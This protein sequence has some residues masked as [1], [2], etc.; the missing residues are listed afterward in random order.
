M[1]KQNLTQSRLKEL[2]HYDPLTGVFTWLVALSNRVKV[3]DVIG[4]LNGEGY[5]YGRVD[6]PLYLIHRLAFLYITGAFPPEDVDHE[7]H[8]RA[9][10]RWTNLRHATRTE[11][12]QNQRLSQRSTSGHTGVHWCKDRKKWLAHVRVNGK[13][14]HLGYFTKKSDAVQTRKAANVKYGFH[15]NH[16]K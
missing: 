7:N 4:C 12:L 8:D 16:G 14:K 3:G 13:S 6:G 11:N 5:L 10:N 9:D 2:V 1:T 15:A